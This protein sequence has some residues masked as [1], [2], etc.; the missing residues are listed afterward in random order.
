MFKF[1]PMK[2][3][4]CGKFD[5]REP[6]DNDFKEEELA[7]YEN[8]EVNCRRCGWVY[9][10]GQAEN[11][12]SHEGHNDLSLSE[13]REQYKAK[14]AENPEYDW[15]EENKPAPAPHKCPVCGEYEFDDEAS[16]DICPVC[17]W[18]DDGME[19]EPDMPAACGLTFPEAVE[20]FRQKRALNPKYRWDEKW[21]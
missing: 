7:E 11:P 19:D 14:I 13:Y 3:P 10:I 17:G 12:E 6:A 1:K 8:G 18:E 21:K 4:V 5:F 16:F 15:F 20:K 9:D 2:C